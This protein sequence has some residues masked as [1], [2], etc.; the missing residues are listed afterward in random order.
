MKKGAMETAVGI[1][2]L[3]GILCSAYLALKLGQLEW[4]GEKYYS[5][6]AYFTTATGLKKGAAVELAGVGVGQVVAIDLDLKSEMARVRL[7][8]QN[9]IVLH[10]DVI[11]SIKTSGL[12]GDKFVNLTPGGSGDQ[13]KNGG[14]I[15][16]T[17]SALDIEE[18]VGKYVF[19]SVK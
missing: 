13:L 17:E 9:N 3:V 4:F 18:L 19:G 12:I 6:D 5:V 11:A 10:D 8:I 2:V 16:D 1:F 7:N 15:M 14:T